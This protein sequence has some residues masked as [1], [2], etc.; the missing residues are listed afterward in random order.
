MT[1]LSRGPHTPL[2][3]QLEAV[4]HHVDKA[5]SANFS[6][7]GMGKSKIVIDTAC[8]LFVEGKID[9]VIVVCPASIR[10]VWFD[11]ELGQLNEH[12]WKGLPALI[13]EY[14]KK[15]RQ[16]TRNQRTGER[17]L[18]WI[19]TNYDFLRSGPKMITRSSGTIAKRTFELIQYCKPT[20]LLV[21]DESSAIKNTMAQQTRACF[22][23]RR[24]CGRVILLNGTPMSERPED[25]LSQ[26]NLM[27]PNIL[28]CPTKAQFRARY[29]IMEPVRGAGG[30]PLLNG[31][32]GAIQTVKAWRN[33]EDLQRR[34]APYVFRRMK[35][36]C[37]DLPEKLPTVPLQVPLTAATWNIYTQMKDEALATLA[38]G[39]SLSPQMT[40]K[41]MRL[42]QIT[43]GFLGGIEEL[44]EA[45][46]DTVF[47]PAASVTPLEKTEKTVGR[48]KLDFVI[49]WLKERIEEDPHFK[50]LI[51]SRHRH[52]ILRTAVELRDNV[53]VPVGIL[54]G[55]QRQIEREDAI[56]LLDPRTT[57]HGP[58]IVIG[59]PASGGK[60][61]TLAAAHTVLYMSCGYS[62]EQ[63]LQSEDRVH[64][65]GQRNVVSYFDLLA[66][67]PKEQKTIDHVIIHALFEKEQLEIMTTKAWSD[68]L[69]E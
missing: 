33:L 25:L 11:P 19:I 17:Q 42:S 28:S 40:T 18:R 23:L 26:G 37:L 14:H 52:E 5:F 15:V 2:A 9:R 13:S 54:I 35:S 62:L 41:L 46:L 20:T 6:E 66:M 49:E 8:T 7:M 30:R 43:S 61:L 67:G 36:E 21:L 29:A 45:D 22:T 1:D 4:E 51:W 64:R 38:Q 65:P 24:H 31:Y 47:D 60:G 50:L 63:R 56:K 16:W 59:H 68:K 12:L 44:G 55:G 57:P 3:H 48:E 10:S 27:S 58:A 34:F 53:N 69:K 32:G 39:V